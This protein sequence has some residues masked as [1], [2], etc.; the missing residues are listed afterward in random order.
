MAHQH[1]GAGWVIGLPVLDWGLSVSGLVWP[2]LLHQTWYRELVGDV[3][4]M[5]RWSVVGL[6]L[7]SLQRAT[8]AELVGLAVGNIVVGERDGSR[9]E[10][11]AR[12]GSDGQTT[13]RVHLSGEFE[14]E[15]TPRDEFEK[16]LLILDLR[17][18]RVPGQ[19]HPNWGVVT[20]AALAQVFGVFQEHIVGGNGMG[21]KGSGR[22]C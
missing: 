2:R 13:Y 17:R 8:R 22:S 20:Q 5:Y 7:L 1:P 12:P 10:V 16:R 6:L 21:A 11:E 15:V 18:L 3:H 19:A 14:Y 9:V 4:Q